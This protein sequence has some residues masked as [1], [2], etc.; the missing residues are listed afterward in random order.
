MFERVEKS[1]KKGDVPCIT[2]IGD[3]KTRPPWIEKSFPATRRVYRTSEL[4]LMLRMVREGIG[5]A[6]MPSVLVEPDPL[7]RPI[8]ARHVEPGWGLWVLSHVDLRTT[9]R[10]RVFRDMLAEDLERIREHIEGIS[11]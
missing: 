9:A 1:G 5:M 11:A 7:L 10:V 2:W 6:Q 4:G 8:P 3:G